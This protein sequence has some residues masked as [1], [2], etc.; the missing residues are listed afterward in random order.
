MLTERKNVF[1]V[2]LTENIL[3]TKHNTVLDAIAWSLG[4]WTLED[5]RD[6]NIDYLADVARESF[7]SFDWDAYMRNKLNDSEYNADPRI[8]DSP[9]LA[10][11]WYEINEPETFERFVDAVRTESERELWDVCPFNEDA[12]GVPKPL[13]DRMMD[14]RDWHEKNMYSEW[15]HGD[16]SNDGVLDTISK[17]LTGERGNVGIREHDNFLDEV[18]ITF[19]EEQARDFIGYN[20]D[21]RDQVTLELLTEEVEG[22][23]H[24]KYNEEGERRKAR[25]E[26]RKAD[27]ACL[28]ER[29][30]K[31]E[32]ARDAAARARKQ[33]A[34]ID[35]TVT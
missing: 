8:K 13:L 10:G 28:E 32:E 2:T 33:Q 23:M 7:K 24:K 27:Q 34:L 17:K 19:T 35:N 5:C 26:K 6:N 14:D 29:S 16:R 11:D 15:L 12:A 9:Y 1:C 22:Y 30:K 25:Y 4:L 3:G 21:E 18:L 20:L 31:E